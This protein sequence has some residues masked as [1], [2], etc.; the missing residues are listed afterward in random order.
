[1]VA[2]RITKSIDFCFPG[3]TNALR[4]G[5]PGGC[6]VVSQT[7]HNIEG[8]GQARTSLPPDAVGYD[9]PD[10]IDLISYFHECDGEPSASFRQYGNDR[11]RRALGFIS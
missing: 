6:W 8:S 2:N 4:L 9:C 3:S 11:A 5:M 10:A 1:M 7:R